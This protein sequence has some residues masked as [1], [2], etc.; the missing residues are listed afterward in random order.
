MTINSD[1]ITKIIRD[2]IGDYAIDIDVAEVGTVVSVG[3][4][5]AQVH[6]VT[7]AVAIETDIL[8]A[9]N[10]GIEAVWITGGL[11]AHFWGVAPEAPPP[12]DR[13]EAACAEH[14]VRPIGVLPLLRW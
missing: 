2:Q 14:G 10:A 3:D 4:G 6:G 8:G 5:I 1:E 12:H 13:V 9:P 7:N 11:P